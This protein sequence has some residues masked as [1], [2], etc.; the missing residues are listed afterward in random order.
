MEKK[1]LKILGILPIFLSIFYILL[2]QMFS[3]SWGIKISILI[4][5]IIIS[6]VSLIIQAKTEENLKTRRYLM[7]SVSLII[8]I[9]IFVLQLTSWQ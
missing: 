6:G 9:L 2:K 8:T 5:I 3:L 4:F 7:L 1:T